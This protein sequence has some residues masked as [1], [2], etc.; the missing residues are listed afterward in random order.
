MLLPVSVFEKITS[1]VS[2]RLVYLAQS[3]RLPSL[4]LQPRNSSK[5]SEECTRVVIREC[6]LKKAL[7]INHTKWA[8][9][10][11]IFICDSIQS[12]THFFVT[13]LKHQVNTLPGKKYVTGLHHQVCKRVINTKKNIG[14]IYHHCQQFSKAQKLVKIDK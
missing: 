10:G 8:K 1:L 14:N 9:L 12:D 4:T 13:F 2:L 5:F 11:G 3:L 7:H 6:C